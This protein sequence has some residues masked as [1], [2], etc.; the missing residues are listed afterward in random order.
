MQHYIEIVLK[1]SLILVQSSLYFVFF[2]YFILEPF[3]QKKSD[4]QAYCFF[5]LQHTQV[6][7]VRQRMIFVQLYHVLMENV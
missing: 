4:W 3:S 6:T 7:G 5:L 2:A 1:Q